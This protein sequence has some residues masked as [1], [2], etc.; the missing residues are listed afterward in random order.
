MKFRSIPEAVLFHADAHPDQLCIADAA[1]AVTYAQ[2]VSAA[3]KAARYFLKAGIQSGDNIVVEGMQRAAFYEIELAVQLIGAVFVPLENKCQ[4]A[5]LSSVARTCIAKLIIGVKAFSEEEAGLFPCPAVT[6]ER[7]FSESAPLSPYDDFYEETPE[8]RRI[9]DDHQIAMPDQVCEILFSTGT[10]GKEKGIVLTHANDVACAE[11]VGYGNAVQPDNVELIPSP[12]NHSH[13]LR[14]LYSNLLFGASVVLVD[15]VFDMKR[16]FSSIETYGVTSMDLVPA[17]LSMILNLTRDKIGDYGEQLRYIEFGSAPLRTADKEKIKAL[18]PDTVLNNF[19]GTTES[20]RTTV[21][22]FNVPAEK[23]GC[24]GKPTKNAGMYIVDENRNIIESDASH[25]GF[26]ASSGAMNMAGY[27]LDPEE[28]ARAMSGGIIYTK[29]E[30]YFDEDGDIILL[31]R[32]DDVINIGGRKVSPEEIE[33][34]VRKIDGVA[35]CVCTAA[36]DRVSGKVPKVYVEMKSGEAFD[37]KAIRAFIRAHTEA[38]KVP[39]YIEQIDRVPR[40]YNGKLLR[41]ALK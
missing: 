31:G 20:G 37:A 38:Y 29:D 22:N 3:Q 15:N 24:I 18:L 39:K 34:I 8:G 2:V 14:S 12:L 35:D 30:A 27:Y 33:D 19:Y 6:Y 16:L 10:T 41:R 26:L 28:T 17:A 13:G 11:N 23:H 21:Y 32:A 4:A 5:K 25:T 40:T 1:G 36:D 7:L 9:R